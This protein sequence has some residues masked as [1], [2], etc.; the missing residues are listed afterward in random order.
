MAYIAREPSYGAF[1]RQTITA[2]G[3][4][5]TF[6]L[7]YAVGSSS[8]VLVSVAGVVQ[9]PT[10]AYGI[11]DGGTKIVFTAAPASGDSVFVIFL[12]LALDTSGLLSTSS[13]TS[14]TDL[15]E[16]PATGD[17]I[18]IHDTSASA[19]KEATIANLFT[20]PTLTTPTVATS[21]DLNGSTLILDADAD[22][23][24]TA[25]TTDDQI[26]IK[27]A[28]TNHLQ[29]KSSSGDTVLKPMVDAKDIVIQQFDGNELVK[30]DDGSGVGFTSFTRAALHPE[31]TLTDASTISWDV[32]TSPVAKVTLG[33]SRALG[34]AT[35]AQ[36]GQFISLLVIQDG[37]GSRTLSFN[38]AYE[39]KDDTA[40]TLT[41]TAAKGDLFV[42]RY[43]GS[44]FLE[45]GRNLN[46]TLS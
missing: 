4:T 37:T 8:S 16:A 40:P 32:G 21:L 31:A 6:T 3:S 17:S 26:D 14:Q 13:I 9:D 18:L 20:S 27:I 33:A 30:F 38:A 5:T 19:L 2:D 23:T 39:F 46:L 29:I 41:T 28:N 1:E 10:G 25:G 12:G 7:N 45:V 42:F 34:A 35:N 15:G 24:I 36:T 43:N 11:S 22:T 44:K